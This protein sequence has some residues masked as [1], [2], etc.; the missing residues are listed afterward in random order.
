MPEEKKALSMKD[1]KSSD[2]RWCT[3][4]GDYTILVGLRKFMVNNQLERENTVNV[5]GIGCSGRIPHYMN[6]YGIHSLHGRSVPVAL[7]I[8]LARPDLNV[9]VHSGDGDSLSIGGNHLMHG[10]KKNFNC[11]YLL[12]DNQIYGLTKNQTSPT[13][14]KGLPTQSQPSGSMLEPINP[15]HFALGLGASFIAST[16]DWLGTHFVDTLDKAFKHNGFSFVHVAQRC[17]KFNPAAWDFQE[18]SWI[19]FLTDETH[20]VANDAKGAPDAKVL[21]HN[22]LDFDEAMK[23]ANGVPDIFGVFYKEDKAVYNDL[24]IQQ[25]DSVEQKSRDSLLD[26][27][28]I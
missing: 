27:F 8:V 26:S 19:T 18:S 9:F 21:A 15:I 6:T 1:L 3:G 28:I 25:N 24:L 12:F 20:G 4:C 11:V 16:A 10:I 22:P 5:S 17:P 23:K 13:T 14:R 2:P 7:G